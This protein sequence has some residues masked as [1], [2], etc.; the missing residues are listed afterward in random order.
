MS[1]SIILKYQN[2]FLLFSRNEE[3]N[4]LYKQIIACAGTMSF[5]RARTKAEEIN[6]PLDKSA[7]P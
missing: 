3:E 6:V 7:H 1:W 2:K 4:T 5:L